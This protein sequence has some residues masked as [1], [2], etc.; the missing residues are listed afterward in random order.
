MRMSL[1]ALLLL[2]CIQPL[3]A[4]E[5]G[6]IGDLYQQ[7]KVLIRVF[8]GVPTDSMEYLKSGVC[9]G[10]LN[11]LNDIASMRMAKTLA[12]G[13]I[14]PGTTSHS[15]IC[16]P[17]DATTDQLARVFVKWAEDTPQSHHLPRVIGVSTAFRTAWPCPKD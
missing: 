4:A 14:V 2:P 3:R 11:G 10:Y 15:R 16:T 6:T 12:D 9:S 7:C 13:R 17:I 8:D 1:L 5:P